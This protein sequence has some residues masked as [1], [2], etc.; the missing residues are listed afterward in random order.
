MIGIDTNILAYA[1]LSA[2]PY[3]KKALSFLEALGESTEVVIS[4]LVLME[5]YVLLRNEKII[6]PPLSA[7]AAC[8]ECN[9]LRTHPHWQLIDSADVMKEVWPIAAQ[10]GFARRRI[11]D[12]RL[13]KT[14]QAHGVTE[15]A[16]ANTKDFEGLGFLRIWNPLR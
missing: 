10:K 2:S 11:F 12:V 3:H 15:F 4:E 16:T 13:A 5:F 1:R 8:K 7:S 6:T 9:L 14:L